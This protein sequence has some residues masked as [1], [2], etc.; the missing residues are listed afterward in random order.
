MKKTFAFLLFLPILYSCNEI[1]GYKFNTATIPT[2]PVNLDFINSEY[3]DYNSTSPVLGETFP[4]CFSSN[5][6]SAGGEYDIIYKLI[7]FNFSKS[8]GEFQ[9]EEET[10]GNMDVFT[11][12]ADLKNALRKINSPFTEFGPYLTTRFPFGNGGERILLYASD[13]FGD[14]DIRFTHNLNNMNYDSIAPISYLNSEFNDYYPAFNKDSSQIYW[15]SDRNGQFDIFNVELDN[16][17]NLLDRLYDNSE[18]TPRTID[19]LNSSSDDKCPFILEDFMVFSSNRP[20]G[21]GGFDLYYS[22]KTNGEWTKPENFGAEINSEHDEYRP[23]IRPQSGE[24]TNDLMI[25]SSNRPA[26]LGGFDLYY[27]GIDRVN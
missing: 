27:V 17:L 12:N 20:G 14:F 15:C 10:N 13:E 26:G 5:R 2:T 6:R 4:I 22:Q 9:I 16:S 24:F 21:F 19:A 7:R 11:E 25:F 18:K 3:D 8:S 1:W 23:I